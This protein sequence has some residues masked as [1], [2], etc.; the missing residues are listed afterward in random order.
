MAPRRLDRRAIA[1]SAVIALLAASV[2]ALIV[3]LVAGDD[4]GGDATASGS[5]ELT[6][7]GDVNIDRLLS[8]Q[9]DTPDG[10]ATDLGD[11]LDGRPLLVNLW[12]SSCVPCIDEMPLLEQ[13]SVD[14]A[15]QLAVVGVA[16]QDEPDA[17]AELAAQTGITYPWV[18]DPEGR[19]FYEARAAG[20]PTTVLL[21]AEGR[22]LGVETGAFV[23][24]DELDAFLDDHLPG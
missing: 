11:L 22:V 3:I 6:D 18:L 5:L 2:A 24:A 12:Q 14:R 19:V 4:G 16:T 8:V 23:D 10:D 20:M 21:D 17:A 1:I 9:L 7:Q 13:A 15:D